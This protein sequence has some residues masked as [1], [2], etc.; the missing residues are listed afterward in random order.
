MVDVGWTATLFSI[1]L[2]TIVSLVCIFW[3]FEHP[4]HW[5]IDASKN[6]ITWFWFYNYFFY[7]QLPTVCKA[8][9]PI[10]SLD[11]FSILVIYTGNTNLH[12][13]GGR[14][15]CLLVLVW[16]LRLFISFSMLLFISH[17]IFLTIHFRDL[18]TPEIEFVKR[19]FLSW[20]V[21]FP[22]FEVLIH[23]QVS[24]SEF[25][26]FV[27]SSLMLIQQFQHWNINC[28]HRKH[29]YWG[30]FQSGLTLRPCLCSENL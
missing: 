2:Q 20:F 29:K 28:F 3:Q 8:T 5:H 22:C 23:F 17:T 6:K 27:S 30:I 13:G 1:E 16:W 18:L 25:Q 14:V 9:Y 11:G 21:H 15:C 4:F 24:S 19:R 12:C 26:P 7:Q 10:Y